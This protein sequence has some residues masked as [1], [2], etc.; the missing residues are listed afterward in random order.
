MTQKQAKVTVHW[1]WWDGLGP[2]ISVGGSEWVMRAVIGDPRTAALATVPT[3]WVRTHKIADEAK[4]SHRSLNVSDTQLARSQARTLL[5]ARA[6]LRANRRP[7]HRP[8]SS[9]Q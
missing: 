1:K 7:T 2:V 8:D 6:S 5:W 3:K 9:F 4:S